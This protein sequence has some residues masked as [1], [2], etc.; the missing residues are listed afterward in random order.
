MLA[1]LMRLKQGIAIA[2]SHGKTTTTSLVRYIL[3]AADLESDRDYR[4]KLNLLDPTR[5]KARGSLGRR[6]RRI[7]GSFLHL[8]PVIAVITNIDPEHLDYYERSMP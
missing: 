1:E 3:R 6:S 4:G 2:G 5:Q 7:D 8:T